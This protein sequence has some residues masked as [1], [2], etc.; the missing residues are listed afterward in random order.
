M[1]DVTERKSAEEAQASRSGLEAALAS[2]TDA[3]SLP[4]RKVA[5]F[6]SMKRTQPTTGSV[7]ILRHVAGDS[8]AFRYFP[9][10]WRVRPWNSGPLRERFAA[11]R[12][13]RLNTQ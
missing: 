5:S 2:M 8:R 1:L 9:A 13:S 12:P 11:K 3:V 7:A 6:I 4:T 10:E